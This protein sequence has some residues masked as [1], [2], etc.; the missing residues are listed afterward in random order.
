MAYFLHLE[1]AVYSC[2]TVKR[3]VADTAREIVD[4]EANLNLDR[5]D[6][7]FCVCD[8]ENSWSGLELALMLG[9]RFAIVQS[10]VKGDCCRYHSLRSRDRSSLA[11][12]KAVVA[13][14][15]RFCET[16]GSDTPLDYSISKI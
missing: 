8:P 10:L 2:A 4:V 11:S 16:S 9:S 6:V 13:P 12:P 15:A 7:N 1:D 3:E 5:G 14:I